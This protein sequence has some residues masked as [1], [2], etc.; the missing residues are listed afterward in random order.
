MPSIESSPVSRM[1]E[2]RTYGLK[3]GLDSIHCHPAETE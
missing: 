2:I 1:R 3:G